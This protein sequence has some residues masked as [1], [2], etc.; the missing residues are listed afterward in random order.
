M[1]EDLEGLGVEPVEGL[2]ELV[3]EDVEALAALAAGGEA[4]E[5]PGQEDEGQ[6]RPPTLSLVRANR[7]SAAPSVG[8][9]PVALGERAVAARSMRAES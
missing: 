4:Q 5:G 8:A 2:K 9:V 1:Q 3:A 6:Q 7:T